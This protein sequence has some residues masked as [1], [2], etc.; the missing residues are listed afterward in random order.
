MYLNQIVDNQMDKLVVNHLSAYRIPSRSSINSSNRSNRSNK[1]NSFT[2][3]NSSTA[4]ISSTT[5][6]SSTKSYH[7]HMFN[8]LILIVSLLLIVLNDVQCNSP[9]KIMPFHFNPMKVQ[10]GEKAL[11]SKLNLLY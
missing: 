3:S 10:D 8:R 1:S 2:R 4:S 6:N 11:A 9:P 5:S 7:H